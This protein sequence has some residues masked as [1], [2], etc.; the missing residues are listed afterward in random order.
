MGFLDEGGFM[1]WN[2][3][4]HIDHPFDTPPVGAEEPYD[5][6]A[7]ADAA[8]PTGPFLYPGVPPAAFVPGFLPPGFDQGAYGFPAAG[9]GPAGGGGAPPPAGR[10]EGAEE[11]AGERGAGRAA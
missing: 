6:P 10:G 4:G 2:N 9:A 3:E 1:A 8:G 7:G 5:L 11:N